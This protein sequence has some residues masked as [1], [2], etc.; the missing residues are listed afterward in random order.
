MNFQVR[1]SQLFAGIQLS[2]QGRLH[3][4]GVREDPRRPGGR[5]GVSGQ[6]SSHAVAKSVGVLGLVTSTRSGLAS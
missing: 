6:S 3:G 1:G 5:G 2:L 4:R